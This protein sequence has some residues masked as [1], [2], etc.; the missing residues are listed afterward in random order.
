MLRLV[1][2][3]WSA[4]AVSRRHPPDVVLGASAAVE[5]DGQGCLPGGLT[6]D[7]EG[8]ADLG[9]GRSLAP[10]GDGQEVDRVQDR[11]S[12]VSC[13]L[14]VVAAAAAGRSASVWSART[15]EVIR[16]LA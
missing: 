2:G 5:L 10:C 7:P 13:V 14:E 11:V 4:V 8:S 6:G 1:A 15:V 9:V 12:G 16:H 3:P